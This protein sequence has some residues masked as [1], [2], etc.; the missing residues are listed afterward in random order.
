M[1][2]T[3]DNVRKKF[4]SLLSSLMFVVV[5]RWRDVIRLQRKA[6]EMTGR[7]N[8]IE[9]SEFGIQIEIGIGIEVGIT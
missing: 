7:V 9:C 3:D 8:F 1:T 5:S 4:A 6:G 2:A